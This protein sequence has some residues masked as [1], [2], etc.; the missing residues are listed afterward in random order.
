MGKRM[1]IEEFNQK[2]SYAGGFEMLTEMRA[3]CFRTVYIAKH[4]SVSADTV[5]VWMNEYFG[6]AK[7][8]REGR[9]AGI[10][11]AMVEF[12]RLHQKSEF[13]LAYKGTS[14]YKDAL[15]ECRKENVYVDER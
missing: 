5:R 1:T 10:I 4:F 11:A 6:L 14:Y 13:D 12:A 9:R 7:D 15:S 8:P 3:L 2:Y